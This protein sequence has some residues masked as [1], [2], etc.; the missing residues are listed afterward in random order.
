MFIT[1]IRRES[2]N[3]ANHITSASSPPEP[4]WTPLRRSWGNED[5]VLTAGIAWFNTG[6]TDCKTPENRS[7]VISI[8]FSIL[9]NSLVFLWLIGPAIF[10]DS[11]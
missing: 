9:N 2:N 1:E 11:L 7:E 4:K 10:L 5:L 8:T 3:I 6:K